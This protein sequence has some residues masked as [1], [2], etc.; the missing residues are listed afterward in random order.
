MAAS[1][2]QEC[3][4]R[5]EEGRVAPGCID[6][7]VAEIV[8]LRRR[9]LFPVAALLGAAVV[10]LPAIASSE[11]PSI[12]AHNEEGVYA[13]SH[14]WMPATATVSSGGTV[15]FSNP[16]SATHHGLRFTGGS[17]GAVPSCSGIPAAASTETGA[18]SWQG[19]C[20][21]STPG[22][23]TFICTVHPSEMTGT[24]TV[25]SSGTTTPAMKT[26][27]TPTTTPTTTPPTTTLGEPGSQAISGSPL[28]GSAAQAV[29][30]ASSQHGKSVHGSVKVSQAGAGGRLEVD[31]LT[32]G[33]LL[34]KAN[35]PS[36]VR[37]GRFLSSAVKAGV[38]SFAVPLTTRAK[39]ALARHH[40]L[41]LAVQIVLTPISGAPDTITRSVV[42]HA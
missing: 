28:A 21:F 31:L 20:T 19:E 36:K 17:A 2:S 37:I 24:I 9:L 33:A 16:Y 12:T 11:T 41:A 40:R 29:K 10:V 39:R 30:L 3:R 5:H 18:T 22:T 26:T 38:V 15:K 23:Y 7:K 6:R 14:S 1:L 8:R 13:K 25:S 27:P 4:I 34:A 42:L 35:R 32:S